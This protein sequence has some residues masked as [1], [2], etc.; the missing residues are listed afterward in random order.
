MVIGVIL[1]AIGVSLIGIGVQLVGFRCQTDGI[2]VIL[3]VSCQNLSYNTNLLLPSM[4]LLQANVL[5]ITRTR[6]K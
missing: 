4:W 3:M 5:M 6:L 1:R 2:G